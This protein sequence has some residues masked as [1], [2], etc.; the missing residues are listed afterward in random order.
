MEKIEILNAI[1]GDEVEIVA[2]LKETW[3]ATY[4]NKEHNITREDILNKDW[5]SKERLEKWRKIISENG[6]NGTFNFVAKAGNKIVGFCLVVKD[7]EFNELKVI[8]VL[9]EYQ[10]KGIGKTLANKG[11]ALLDPDKDT[12]IE[13]VEYNKGAIGFYEKLGFV[14]FEKGKGHEVS[15]GKIMPTIRMKLNK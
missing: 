10:G 6:K 4:P 7:K 9:P 3:L 1:Q 15:N 5:G 11:L 12:I 13:V 2:L 14:E 8:Y